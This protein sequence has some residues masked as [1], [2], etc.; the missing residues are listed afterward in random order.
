[1][2]PTNVEIVRQANEHFVRTGEPLWERIHPQIEFRDHDLPDARISHGHAGFAEFVAPWDA[3]FA[4]YELEPEEYLDGG[5]TVVM[6]FM[7]RATGRG[8]GIQLE[9]RDA[10]VY[11]VADGLITRMDY[12]NNRTQALEAAGLS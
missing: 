9:R 8:S 3:A 6:V 11:E 12:F 5:D 10:I 7:M 4:S 1:M 2:S